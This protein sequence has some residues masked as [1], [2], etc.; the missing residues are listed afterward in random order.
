MISKIDDDIFKEIVSR[1]FKAYQPLEIYLFG[2][3][4]WGKPTKYSDIDFFIIL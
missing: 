1:L 4:A 3:Y 2:S